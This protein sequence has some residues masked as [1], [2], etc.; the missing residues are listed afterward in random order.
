MKGIALLL[1]PLRTCQLSFSE[2]EI[3]ISLSDG[4]F[5]FYAELATNTISWQ[6]S[7]PAVYVTHRKRIVCPRQDPNPG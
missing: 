5:Y 1:K 4:G 7:Q 6:G 3:P 2:V